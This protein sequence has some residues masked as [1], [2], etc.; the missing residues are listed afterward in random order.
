M[1]ERRGIERKREKL[2]KGRKRDRTDIESKRDRR[3]I[4][5][6]RDRTD[7]ESKRDRRETER[8]EGM[9]RERQIKKIETEGIYRVRK[10]VGV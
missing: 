8:L 10:T 4:E 1:R 3:D 9:T 5:R 2:D 7:I 6:K